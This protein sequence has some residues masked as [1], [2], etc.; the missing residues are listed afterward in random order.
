MK[1]KPVLIS[2][3]IVLLAVGVYF[4]L[5]S[6]IASRSSPYQHAFSKHSSTKHSGRSS[7]YLDDDIDARPH[8]SLEAKDNK[9]RSLPV[10]EDTGKNTEK[11]IPDETLV[12]FDSSANYEQFL[13]EA[14]RNNMSIL[15]KIPELNAI[16]LSSDDGSSLFNLI[17]AYDE[18]LEVSPNFYVSLPQESIPIVGDENREPV[19]FNNRLLDWMGY[20]EAE[21][22]W[23]SGV[24]VAVIDSGI[25]NHPF[26]QGVSIQRIQISS[27]ASSTVTSASTTSITASNAAEE[28]TLNPVYH[29]TAVAS[30]IASNHETAPGIAPGVSLI[31]I[32][33][34]DSTG[35]GNT[36]SLAE[37]IVL[38]T[39]AGAAIINLSLQSYGM[40][41]VM[42]AAIK[43][44]NDRGVT[45]VAASG[46]DGF[47]E[48]AYP[49][50][51]A[52]VVA[53]GAIDLERLHA[54]FSNGGETL[55]VTAPGVGLW[56]AWG[57]NEVYSFSGTSAATAVVS[58]VLSAVLSKDADL[59]GSSLQDLL[60]RH[61]D[62]AGQAGR[63]IV[64]GNGIINLARL[65][66]RNQRGIYDAALANHYL[67]QENN[68]S[69]VTV[70]SIIQN[71]G[72]EPLWNLIHNVSVQNVPRM[73]NI[74]RLEVGQVAVNE[75]EVDQSRIAAQSITITSKVE[76]TQTDDSKPLNNELS[77][78]IRQKD[79]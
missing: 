75:V 74:S 54:G 79:E 34:L 45:L 70:Q 4:F 9:D 37:A 27:E 59:K 71:Q 24:I 7:F 57:S 67:L 10:E 64:Y 29:G 76:V 48:L 26:F 19:P 17:D 72:T 42:E 20:E 47:A 11:Q 60:S 50:R 1:K 22:N 39:Q 46:N 8:A 77:A 78:V 25:E 44:A 6:D 66:Q 2:T 52:A 55:D 69:T 18:A 14:Q 58:G 35:S 31:D 23:G 28:Q 61:A 40:N 68:A 62:D 33:V 53:V 30:L 63:D 5:D 13:L 15:S 21:A 49:A 56:V 12:T 32:P 36:F 51:H 43:Y 41:T 38:A 65:L 3:A 16:R 73:F